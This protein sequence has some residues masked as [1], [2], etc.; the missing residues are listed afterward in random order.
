MELSTL[1]WQGWRCLRL[2]LGDRELLL[3]TEIGPR[4]LFA[5]FAEGP[6]LLGL[7]NDDIGQQG[8]EAHHLYGGHRLWHAPEDR[9]RTYLPDNAPPLIRKESSTLIVEQA[10]EVESGIQKILRIFPTATGQGF[11]L[12]HELRN[13][14]LWPLRF[15]PWAL[16]V[17]APA[18]RAILPLPPRSEHPRDLLPNTRLIFWPYSNLKDARWGWGEGFLR[19]RQDPASE[20]PQKVGGS[21][22]AGWLA[23]AVAAHLF[24]KTFPYL[25]GATYPDDGCNAEIFANGDF[26]ELES[27]GP[28]REIRPGARAIHEERWYFWQN[29]SMNPMDEEIDTAVRTRLKELAIDN[30]NAT[31]SVP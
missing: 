14:T 6:N 18:G 3:P 16:T 9:K 31:L 20:Q 24:V 11:V 17:M 7:L 23:Y 22:P 1:N 28:L 10:P 4:V 2:R 30:R 8:G 25:V 26:L 29:F 5:G 15:A 12:R 27:L 19:L 13:T 21:V